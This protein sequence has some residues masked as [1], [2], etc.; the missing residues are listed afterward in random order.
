MYLVQL[1]ISVL[2][3]D[4][5]ACTCMYMISVESMIH[6]YHEY[7]SKLSLVSK[8]DLLKYCNVDTLTSILMQNKLK[9]TSHC[10]T[11]HVTKTGKLAKNW[12]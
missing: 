10:C 2:F 3:D 9:H 6:G 7:I 12:K 4:G 11:P 1:A 5:K 8:L